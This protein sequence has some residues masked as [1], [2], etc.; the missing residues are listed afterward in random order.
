MVFLT[1]DVHNMS[2]NVK[3]QSLLSTTELV[4]A[5]KYVSI[6]EE[7]GIKVTLFISGKALAEEPQNA[8]KLLKHADLEIGGH[9]WNSFAFK[10]L[11]RAFDLLYG[12]PFGP[13]S[14]QNWDIRKTLAQIKKSTGKDPVSWR[15]HLYAENHHTHNLL[16]KHGIKVVSNAVGPE[17]RIKRLPD[18]LIS[19][20]VNIMPDHEYVYH[21]V[22]TPARRQEQIQYYQRLESAK[23]KGW[24]FLLDEKE[25]RFPKRSK[26]FLKAQLK[27]IL[28][29][30]RPNN[31]L[32]FGD[33]KITKEDWLRRLK[34]NIPKQ[35]SEKGFATLEI[36]PICMSVFDEMRT[37]VEICKF[38]KQYRTATLRES[39]NCF[40]S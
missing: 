20:P 19:V 21:G 31:S 12:S 8:D 1:G 9:T 38:L 13:K 32:P 16:V 17:K 15:S 25:L 30:G 40:D 29:K 5:E 27:A 3:H 23:R 18:G 33:Q 28:N 6:A 37:F 34:D 24:S 7:H 39:V 22:I 2:L 36:H 35:L 10:R 4:A 14:Y 26:I 11:H